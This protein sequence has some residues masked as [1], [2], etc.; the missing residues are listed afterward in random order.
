MLITD[1]R[2]ISTAEKESK[3]ERETE[4]EKV[5]VDEERWRDEEI[6]RDRKID[7]DR[8]RYIAAQIELWS[9]GGERQINLGGRQKGK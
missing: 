7:R 3:I 8:E 6:V 1:D 5:E 2:P 9:E 4:I